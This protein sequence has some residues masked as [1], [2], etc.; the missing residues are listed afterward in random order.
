ME[1]GSERP[2]VPRVRTTLASMPQA[3]QQRRV[4]VAQC[5]GEKR[6]GG[7]CSITSFTDMRD[8]SSG[9]LVAEP[10]RLGCSFCLFHLQVFTTRREPLHATRLP[11][12]TV[13][14]DF[15][16]S[17]LDVC[18][19]NVVEIGAVHLESGAVFATLVQP[20]T[21][22]NEA[23]AVNGIQAQELEAAPRFDVAIRR[24]LAFLKELQ[25]PLQMEVLTAGRPETEEMHRG[26]RAPESPSDSQP[27]VCLV[28]HN[29]RRFDFP[30]LCA[31]CW[32]HGLPLSRLEECS[33]ADSLD[34]PAEALGAG[35]A[36]CLKLQ[37]LVAST[38]H[39]ASPCGLPQGLPHGSRRR[40]RALDDALAL[41]DVLVTAASR[42]G[43]KV[44]DLLGQVSCRLDSSAT[45]ATLQVLGV[46]Q[47]QDVR[48]ESPPSP[49]EEICISRGDLGAIATTQEELT[50]QEDGSD[51]DFPEVAG[52]ASSKPAASA[53]SPTQWDWRPLQ[54]LCSAQSQTPSRRRSDSA[55]TSPAKRRK[56]RPKALAAPESEPKP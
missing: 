17:G 38:G 31:E 6:D 34:L 35:G 53:L 27:K 16:T 43:V 50:T 33:F 13:L 51:S 40:H 28:A 55:P 46:Q 5:Q 19:A 42:L 15:E 12:V 47:L 37:C 10:L 2:H 24:F 20:A 7:R 36:G 18:S 49:A 56:L 1:N 52:E 45:E 44:A 11:A 25:R 22:A 26:A 39:S 29:G 48:R 32:R 30:V 8:R 3:V 21:S 54:S 23:E 9:K 4:P 14:L 41:R